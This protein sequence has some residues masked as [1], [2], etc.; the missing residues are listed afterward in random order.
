MERNEILLELRVAANNIE[1]RLIGLEG[2]LDY[3]EKDEV[4][5][6]QVEGRKLSD[7]L[8]KVKDKIDSLN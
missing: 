5:G 3:C 2:D 6:I 4:V 7:K 8:I 1:D